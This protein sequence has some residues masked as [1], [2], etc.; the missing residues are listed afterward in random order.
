[1]N[2]NSAILIS[3]DELSWCVWRFR[4]KAKSP[5]INFIPGQYISIIIDPSTRRQY[6][7]SNYSSASFDEFEIIVDIKPNGVGTTY[8]KNLY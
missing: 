8:L 2:I 3:K 4:L 1:M 5:L 7:I 6:S